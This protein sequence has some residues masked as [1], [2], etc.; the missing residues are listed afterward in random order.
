[1]ALNWP[2]FCYSIASNGSVECYFIA[3]LNSITPTV[4]TFQVWSYTV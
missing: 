4:I 3:Y 1:M 2:I